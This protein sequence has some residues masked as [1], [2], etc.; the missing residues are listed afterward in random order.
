MIAR[1]SPTTRVRRCSRCHQSD[2]RFPSRAATKCTGCTNHLDAE[3]A[4]RMAA[5]RPVCIAVDQ[6]PVG[7]PRHNEAHLAYIRSLPCAVKSR[8]C[9]GP[10]HPHHVRNG[11][12]GGTSMKPGDEWAVP[13]C[14][15]HH[16]EDGHRHGWVTFEEKHRIDLRALAE[17]L[18]AR[19]PYLKETVN[20]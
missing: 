6:E 5:L 15:Y 17:Q 10:I 19:S 1:P 3:R 13:I 7:D 20:G 16:L 14:A 9:K 2:V 4:A 8:E 18:A 11:T 12:G